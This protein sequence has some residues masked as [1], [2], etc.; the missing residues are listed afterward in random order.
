LGA[1]FPLASV[2]WLRCLP[3]HPF[4]SWTVLPPLTTMGGSD[5]CTPS[6]PPSFS[7]SELSPGGMT[8]PVESEQVSRVRGERLPI[9]GE[10]SFILSRFFPHMPRSY[11]TPVEPPRARHGAPGGAAF[12][13]TLAGRP[14][15]L[16]SYGAVLILG[17]LQDSLRPERFPV[18]ASPMLF[19]QPS[20]HAL[21]RNFRQ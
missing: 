21:R 9:S 10:A 13:V 19:R 12:P 16:N 5:P 17:S 14:P 8:P 3:A 18:Y 11:A 2:L 6:A 15:H 20:C 1:F 7:W 4:A